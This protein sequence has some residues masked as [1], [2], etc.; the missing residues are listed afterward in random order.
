MNTYSVWVNGT[1]IGYIKGESQE[2]VYWTIVGADIR[3]CAVPTV[4][5]YVKVKMENV[6]VIQVALEA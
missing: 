1:L 5:G 2:D 3:G 6:A 4:T